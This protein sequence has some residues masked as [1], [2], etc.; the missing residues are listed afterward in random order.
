MSCN[1]GWQNFTFSL[2]LFKNTLKFQLPFELEKSDILSKNHLIKYFEPPYMSPMVLFPFAFLNKS[3]PWAP[4]CWLCSMF[5]TS[6]AVLSQGSWL[7]WRLGQSM[8]PPSPGVQLQMSQAI[9]S[10][11][12]L[13]DSRYH[14]DG[15]G[16]RSPAYFYGK[17]DANALG[18]LAGAW[19]HGCV[20]RLS[21]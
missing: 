10:R 13:R 3:C 1:S 4:T 5:A 2:D 8:S 19:S 18:C 14:W 20:V 6:G 17:A 9:L 12:Q 7:T 16:L 11:S 15:R 21:G